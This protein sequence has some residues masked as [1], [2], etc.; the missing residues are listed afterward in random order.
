[1]PNV[2][3]SGASAL[4]QRLVRDVLQAAAPDPALSAQLT[5]LLQQ[6]RATVGVWAAPRPAARPR[7]TPPPGDHARTVPA[8]AAAAAAAA[9][10]AQA[11]APDNTVNDD[12]IWIDEGSDA[13]AADAAEEARW[14]AVPREAV[15]GDGVGEAEDELLLPAEQL[16]EVLRQCQ[17]PRIELVRSRLPP[18][19][20]PCQVA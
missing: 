1:M 7:A 13:E 3:G 17:D 20:H 4:V 14:Q 19:T 5:V 6:M 2:A 9:A 10:V 16:V 15:D 18:P 12:E 11:P 8:A